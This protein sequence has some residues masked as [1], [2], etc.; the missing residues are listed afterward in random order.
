MADNIGVAGL[1]VVQKRQLLAEAIQKEKDRS[2]HQ[3]SLSYGQRALWYLNQIAPDSAA[4]NVFFRASITSPVEPVIMEHAVQTAVDRHPSLRTTYEVRD[5]TPLQIVHP[6]LK[7]MFVQLDV[8]GASSEEIELRLNEFSES[9]F[10]LQRGPGLRVQ[11]LRC[12]DDLTILAL[13]VHHIAVDYLSMELLIS[14][15]MTFYFETEGGKSPSLA[16]SRYQYVDHVRFEAE[17][18]AGAEGKRHWDYWREQ[19]SGTLPTLAM[20]TDRPRPAIQTFNGTAY[21]FDLDAALMSRLREIATRQNT[22]LYVLMLAGVFAFLHRYTHQTDIL[23]GSPAVGRTRL[24]FENVLGYFT[25]PIAL[26]A[27]CPDNPRFTAFLGDVNETVLTGLEH[28]EYP[29]A[30]V[31]EQLQPVRDPSRSPLFQVMFVWYPA[32]RTEVPTDCGL[33]FETFG[34]AQHGAPF[35]LM[36]MMSESG[37][38]GTSTFQYNTDLFDRTTIARMAQHFTNILGAIALD[39]EQRLSELQLLNEKERHLLLSEW[40]NTA[41]SYAHH[42]IHESFETQVTLTPNAIALIAGEVRLTYEQLDQR[43]NKLA[44]YLVTLGVSSETIVGVCLERSADMVVTVLAVLKA[45]GAYL[46]MDPEYPLARLRFYAE[47][48]AASIVVTS[49]LLANRLFYCGAKVVFGAKVVRLD[50][51]AMAINQCVATTARCRAAPNIMSYLIYTSGSTGTPKGVVIEHRNAAAL[52]DWARRNF[53]VHERTGVLASTSICFDLSVFEM[54]LPLTTGGKVILVRNLAVLPQE[55]AAK[56]VTLINTVPSV[57][58]E[59]LRGE[60]LPD[61]VCAVCLAGEPLP[62]KVVDELYR[63][64]GISRVFNLYG[65]TEDTTY[66]T[67]AM[68]ER[69]AARPPSIGRPISNKQVYLLDAQRQPVP[70]GVTGEL[71]IGGSGLARGYLNRPEL[72][73]ERFVPNPFVGDADARLYRTGDLARYSSDGNI[74]FLGRTD[75][76]VKIRGFRIEV[77][78]I[79]SVLGRHPAVLDVVVS[80]FKHDITER[81]LVAHVQ[82]KPGLSLTVGDLRIFLARFLPSFMIPQDFVF[83]D[84][85]PRTSN[86]KIDRSALPERSTDRP[87]LATR[88]AA[89]ARNRIEEKLVAIWRQSLRVKTVG[90]HDNF[91]ELGGASLQSL[92]IASRARRQGLSFP[93]ELLF[94]YPTIAEL[95]LVTDDVSNTDV[96]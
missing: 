9:P 2:V 47:D 83:L 37:G 6:S 89:P 84:V 56:E 26:R 19:L 53:S 40:N 38:S 51:D 16:R 60:R 95:A 62:Q 32:V 8:R 68:V 67:A 50:V 31:V 55:P 85:L 23:V 1:S 22:T 4:Y 66:S 78:E 86:G 88:L 33:H 14:E 73:A 11:L 27:K 48:S 80:A 25:N 44:N 35:D 20:P 21:H 3:F 76:Q 63:Y 42:C 90:I 13:A 43:A 5:G 58:A 77:G 24:G 28:H 57:M 29:F 41:V 70:I 75:N 34:S 10:D 54:F 81:R 49:D 69:D 7:A 30:L 36:I 52:L 18:V 93:P 39:P 91:L 61:S 94:V 92:E 12:T 79:E 96:P 72:S 71:Y 45:G 17:M 59:F 65:P 82:T 64:P 74:E 46:P 15:L 87:H